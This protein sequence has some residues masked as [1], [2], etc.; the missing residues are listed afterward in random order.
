MNSLPF[1]DGEAVFEVDYYGI[2]DEL[3]IDNYSDQI[4]ELGW[5]L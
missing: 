4:E 2:V 1:E 3:L 5:Q